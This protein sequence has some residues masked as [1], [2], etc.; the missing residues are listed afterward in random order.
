[1][2]DGEIATAN[3]R[4]LRPYDIPPD[5]PY[6]SEDQREL[7]TLDSKGRSEWMAEWLLLAEVGSRNAHSHGVFA[8]MRPAVPRVAEEPSDY[9]EAS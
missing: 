9:P 5:C 7:S 6:L 1:M 8:G 3:A 2:T 4:L